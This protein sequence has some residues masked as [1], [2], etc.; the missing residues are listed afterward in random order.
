MKSLCKEVTNGNLGQEWKLLSGSNYAYTRV[1]H[2][3]EIGLNDRA[4]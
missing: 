2:R 3:H 4:F 1:T